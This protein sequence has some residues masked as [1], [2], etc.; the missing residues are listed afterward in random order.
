M[1]A[2][3]KY[4]DG[5]GENPIDEQK[6]LFQIDEEKYEF[7]KK[8]GHENFDIKCKIIDKKT[9]RPLI[10]RKSCSA[11]NNPHY[12]KC[13]VREIYMLKFF[14]HE[15]IVKLVDIVKPEAQ[16]NSKDISFITEDMECSLHQII[17]SKQTLTDDHV[18]FFIYQ[19]L[20]GIFYIHSADVVHRDLR[21]RTLFVNSHSELKIWSFNYAKSL[22]EEGNINSE[23]VSVRYYR[24]PELV[25]DE[26]HG[27]PVDI[28]AIGCILTELLR[29]SP[30]FTG[31]DYLD[32]LN[33]IL[34]IIG[35]PEEDDLGW[36]QNQAGLKYIKN[37]PKKN[38]VVW[39]DLFPDA[40]PDLLDL[41]DKILV[42]NPAKRPTVQECLNHPYFHDI[43]DPEEMK[44]CSEKFVWPGDE[45]ETPIETLQTMLYGE[46][47][48]S[49]SSQ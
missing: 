10:M 45:I 28:W 8:I 15:N 26:K 48:S 25:L 16:T 37:L 41:I 7:V 42:F 21:P 44:V 6:K 38:R 14:D 29:R 46:S 1:N 24:A 19:V 18:K 36:I 23:Y 13:L 27:K 43:Y 33:K 35:T 12:A 39:K 40:N 49:G 31:K 9:K 30:L 5:I 17:A 47:Q 34:E 2:E 3:P 4:N 22:S 20:A 11:F 32:Q